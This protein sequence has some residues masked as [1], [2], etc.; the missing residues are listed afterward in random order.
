MFGE[1]STYRVVGENDRGIEVEVIDAP[2]LEPGHRFTFLAAD[3]EAMAS[4][5]T[6][7]SV[8]RQASTRPALR[9]R[10]V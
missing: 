4:A 8:P 9:S 3:V 1:E 6:P 10:H 5:E 7:A 2:G